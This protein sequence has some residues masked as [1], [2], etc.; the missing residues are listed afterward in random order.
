[1][2]V[3]TRA[4]FGRQLEVVGFAGPE[5]PVAAE[6][7]TARHQGARVR[8]VAEPERM[9]Y[10]VHQEAAQIAEAELTAHDGDPGVSD[11]PR[12]RA[13]GVIVGSPSDPA[14]PGWNLVFGA[15]AGDE[16]DVDPAGPRSPGRAGFDAP[17]PRRAEDGRGPRLEP[18]ADQGH[19]VR[20]RARGAQV[21]RHGGRI[22]PP[23][24]DPAAHRVGVVELVIDELLPEG[25]VEPRFD[26]FRRPGRRDRG[27]RGGGRDRS[28]RRRQPRPVVVAGTDDGEHE[29]GGVEAGT[30]HGNLPSSA[31]EMVTG[32]VATQVARWSA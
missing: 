1:M 13:A 26:R 31:T 4:D 14:G 22:G 23:N 9:A 24:R 6:D 7:A 29:R 11:P 3:D 12:A 27:R 30:L 10:L 21:D 18:V 25:V 32:S 19:G 20:R 16:A 28:W 5:L 2:T 8:D 17:P 15:A